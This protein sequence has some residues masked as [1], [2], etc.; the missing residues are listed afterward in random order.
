[1]PYEM[2]R[3]YC[4]AAGDLEEERQAFHRVMADFNEQHAMKRNI[5]LVSVSLPEKLVDKR[6]YQSVISENIRACSYYIQLIEDTWGPPQRNF[7]KD[8][9]LAQ[10][11]LE[12]PNQKM[13]GVE[14]M[15][16]RPLLPNKVDPDVLDFKES[17]RPQDDKFFEFGTTRELEQRLAERL[18]VWLDTI[19]PAGSDG[20]A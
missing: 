6:G 15:F 20:T 8:Y 13:Q 16:K 17:L 5:L 11:C 7:E 2:H 19:A 1:M 12:D 10:R 14:V 3:I 4:A 9:A 18:T